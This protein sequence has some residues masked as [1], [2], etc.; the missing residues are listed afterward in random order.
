MSAQ[1]VNAGALL[2]QENTAELPKAPMESPKPEVPKMP[3]QKI[4]PTSTP[5]TNAPTP[6]VT[7]PAPKKEELMVHAVETYTTDIN[8]VMES[9]AVS[10]VTIAA[11]EAE[12]RAKATKGEPVAPSNLAPKER[13]SHTRMALVI[14][15]VLLILGALAI[16]GVLLLR[17]APQPVAPVSTGA[18]TLMTVDQVIPVPGPANIL[19]D[20]L[21]T[22][23]E[24]AREQVSLSVGLVAQ[25]YVGTATSTGTLPDLMSIN[26]LL[27]LLSPT[28]PQ[29]LLLTIEPTYLLGVHSYDEN[30][31]FLVLRVDSYQQA[32]AG[33][34][35]W[36][37]S[38]QQDLAPLFTR[39]PSPPLQ[40]SD[41]ATSTATSSPQFLQTGFVDQTVENHDARVILN[42]TG[43]ILLL[44]TFLDRNTVVITTNE[45]TLR[46]VI[47]RLNTSSLVPQPQQ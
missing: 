26:Q 36:E 20:A 33:M 11:A 12:R 25:L 6:P 3:E 42:S 39:T 13:H 34:L 44:W 14:G 8:R 18:S 32:Y 41:T 23:L 38:M 1:R 4:Q 45:Y 40:N 10:S 37:P 29:D 19:R 22:N 27:S 5:V 47:R 9:G 17:A 15:G 46:E 43:D 31:P 24:A 30:Q 2:A 16:V 7:P 21:V 35:A 28:I